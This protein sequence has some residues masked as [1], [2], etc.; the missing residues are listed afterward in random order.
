ML[1]WS[2][3]KD[4]LEVAKTGSLSAAAKN[5]KVSQPTLGRRIQA[6]ED[7]LQSELFVRT[8]QGLNLTKTG[9]LILDHSKRMQEEAYG[10]ERLVMGREKNLSGTVVISLVEGMATHW[11][12]DEL[13][14]FYR[15]YPKITLVIQAEMTAADLLRRE[16]DIAIRL[17]EPKQMDLISRKGGTV[18]LGLYASKKYLKEHGTP[19][20][21][22]ELEEHK[23]LIHSS[24]HRPEENMIFKDKKLNLKIVPL[25]S[26]NMTIILNAIESGLG[27]GV[28]ANIVASKD[29][30]LV[31]LFPNQFETT[32]DFWLVSH[33][34][35]RRS[36][37]I[38][39]V[40]DFLSN[41]VDKNKELF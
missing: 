36:A 22:G 26:N 39:A 34:E 37:R 38:R 29:P 31:Q 40:Y 21:L 27:I 19:K 5:L 8:P 2:R 33:A 17:F 7:D 25:I 11:L 3:L 23:F 4:F 14:D 10:V 6:L 35:L 1:N 16:A 30:N 15:Q 13:N 18:R 20:T 12:I 32:L 28:H 9:E 41:L 24:E